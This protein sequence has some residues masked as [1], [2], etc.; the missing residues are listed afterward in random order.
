[1]QH[2]FSVGAIY[3]LIGAVANPMAKGP[4]IKKEVESSH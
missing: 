1:M 2:Q 3:L 4:N